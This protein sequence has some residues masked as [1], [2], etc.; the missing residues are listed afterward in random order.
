MAVVARAGGCCEY[1]L[2]P[3][4]GQVSPFPMDH[5]V[6]RS[7]GGRTVLKNLAL[8]C[9]HCNAYKWAHSDGEDPVT[10]KSVPLFNPR[11]QTW[12]EH[13]RWSG[14]FPIRIEGITACGRATVWR[15]RMN[16]RD[17]VVVR[18]LLARLGIPLGPK[19]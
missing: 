1:C 3:A 5:I 15:L 6:P 8:A 2:L 18:R 12:S 7:Q 9:P 4:A 14:R 10:G 19:A 17:V 11:A 13:F 16:H